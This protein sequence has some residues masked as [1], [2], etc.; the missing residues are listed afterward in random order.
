MRNLII[1]EVGQFAD[2]H[3]TP[4]YQIYEKLTND[5]YRVARDLPDGE[6]NHPVL[7]KDARR[8][9]IEL[10][11]ATRRGIAAFEE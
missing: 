8:R 1:V 5:T 11:R 2:G 9:I 10:N 3:G 6:S 7:L 4:S